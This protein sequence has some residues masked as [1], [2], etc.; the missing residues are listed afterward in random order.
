MKNSRADAILT[1]VFTVLL[2]RLLAKRIGGCI[3]KVFYVNFPWECSTSVNTLV[4]SSNNGDDDHIHTLFSFCF[5]VLR[6]RV[7]L[8][9]YIK[10]T[11]STDDIAC[12]RER[13]RE[14]VLCPV[15]LTKE[16]EEKMYEHWS[17]SSSNSYCCCSHLDEQKK[18]KRDD[19]PKRFS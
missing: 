2:F 19:S 5:I 9:V 6:S 3:D 10:F 8:S 15:W 1:K 13:E 11:K 14:K 12:N 7:Y 18:E 4:L 16:Q 17:R